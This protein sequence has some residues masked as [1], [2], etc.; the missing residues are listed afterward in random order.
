MFGLQF[1]LSRVI[2][3][4]L[5]QTVAQS[6][7]TRREGVDCVAGYNCKKILE[8][9]NDLKAYTIDNNYHIRLALSVLSNLKRM[10]C[11]PVF[12]FFLS[13]ILQILLFF[14]IRT[15]RVLQ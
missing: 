11:F 8:L 6:E 13:F 3:T 12:S 1:T 7:A 10:Q 15:V 14:K 4:R 2:F 9:F 5:S